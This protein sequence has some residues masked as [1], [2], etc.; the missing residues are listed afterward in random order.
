MQE[1]FGTA[2]VRVAFKGLVAVD[3]VSVA[4]SRGEIVGLIG[5]NG[6][7]KTTLLNV[8]SG[9]QRPNS[10]SIQV[11]GHPLAVAGPRSI[12]ARG[13]ARTFQSGRLFP[14]LTI[15][16]NFV[17][18]AVC[19]GL[20]VAAGRDRAAES[21]AF[22]EIGRLATV[23]VSAL[24][25]GLQRVVALGR[26]LV[27]K[28]RFLLLDEPAAGL[29]ESEARLLTSRLKRI[30]AEHHCGIMIVEHDM[31]VIMNLCDRAH[32]LDHG[33]TIWE[34]E[35]AGLRDDA[36]VVEAYLGHGVSA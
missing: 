5:P 14:N 10:G 6:A 27:S 2:D 33:A 12:A 21:L 23:R 19:G 30:R 26:A 4:V 28:P 18:A 8:M 35:P 32:V 24:P 34:G 15:E 13:V 3:G 22:L 9:L 25:H 31:S 16:E 20:G 1:T 11:D 29:N 36:A 7:G 17:Y